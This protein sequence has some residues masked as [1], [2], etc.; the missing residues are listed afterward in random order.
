MLKNSIPMEW[1][2]AVLA[3]LSI[4]LGVYTNLPIW[5]TYVTWAGAFLVAPNLEGI[6]KL[7]PTLI[8][9]TVSGAIFFALTFRIDPMVSAPT[10]ANALIIFAMALGLF[11][12]ARVPL[13]GLIPGIFFGF[14]CYVGVAMAAQASTIPALFAPWVHATVALLLGP[15]LAWISVLPYVTREMQPGAERAAVASEKASA[16]G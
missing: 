7:Y 14:S 10:L 5:A 16:A 2:I 6:R 1:Y 4:P 3:A 13:F 15:P 8:L 12:L 9:G 11:Y